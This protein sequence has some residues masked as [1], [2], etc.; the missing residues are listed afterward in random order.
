[1]RYEV[2]VEALNRAIGAY[3]ARMDAAEA[4]PDPTSR[5][6]IGCGPE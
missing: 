4:A 3:S 2:A 6:S 1:V 5:C